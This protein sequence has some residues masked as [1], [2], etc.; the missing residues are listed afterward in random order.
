MH[1]ISSKKIFFYFLLTHLLIW[2][3]IPSLSNN[4]LP[5]DTIEALAWGSN[6]DWGFDKHPPLSAFAVEFIFR[7]FGNQ[8]W[9]YYLLSQIFVIFSFFIV[10]LFSNKFFKNQKYCLMSILILEG[11]C[12][13]N[14]TTPEFNVNISQMPFWA[15]TVLFAYRSFKEN[16]TSDWLLFGV[17][18]AFGVLSKYLFFYLLAAISIF[19]IFLMPIKNFKLKSLVSLISFFLILSPH[20]AWLI[21]NDFVTI[22][23]GLHRST[24]SFY[25]GNSSIVNHFVYPSIFLIKQFGILIPFFV[26]LFFILKKFKV[27]LNFNDNKLIFLLAINLIPIILIFLTSLILGI[28]IR[29]MWMTPFYLF[30]GVLIIYIFKKNIELNK[31]KNFFI[32]FC[33][34]FLFSPI[35]YFLN[36]TFKQDQRIDYPAKYISDEVQ[37]RWDNNFKNKINIVVG[38]AWWAGNLSYHLESRPMY[39]R[40]YLNFVGEKLKKE[41]GIIYIEHINSKN[42]KIC[43]GVSFTIY[44]RYICM[45]GVNK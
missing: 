15:L 32:V 5:R 2:T 1:K 25:T 19:F 18:A 24:D 42:T 17:C 21:N 13:Y 38:Q 8:D 22:T 30:F 11:I 41:D 40:G 36:S 39:I 9:A 31:I 28:K 16:K 23:Y 35:I 43:P 37:K 20:I 3:L 14:F 7:I 26:I 12:F 4:N 33:F 29:T 44:S 34:I 6:L 10:W 45:V 27:K